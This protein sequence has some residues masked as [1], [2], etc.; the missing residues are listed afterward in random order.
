MLLRST[1]LSL[2]TAPDIQTRRLLEQQVDRENESELR[3][4]KA[5]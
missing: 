5:T 3:K 4:V 1:I 2:Y